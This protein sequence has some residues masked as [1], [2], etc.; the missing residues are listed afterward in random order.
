MQGTQGKTPTVKSGTLTRFLRDS[1]ERDMEAAAATSKMA[2]TDLLADSQPLSPQLS[3]CSLKSLEIN[4]VLDIRDLLRNLPLKT[5]MERMIHKLESSL[6][7]KMAEMGTEIQ[8]LDL[9]AR[10]ALKPITELLRNRSIKYRCSFPFAL[11]VNYK[12]NI[13]QIASILDVPPFLR[14]LELPDTRITDWNYPIPH[15]DNVQMCQR[16]KWVTPA[17]MRRNDTRFTSPQ[18]RRGRQP[19]TPARKRTATDD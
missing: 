5:D 8:Q 13:I 2:G 4:P 17:K 18:A 10:R 6:H 7:S 19:S 11:I 15:Q 14:A 12:G 1:T 3:E 16:Q 9:K